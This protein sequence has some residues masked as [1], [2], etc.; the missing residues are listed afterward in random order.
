MTSGLGNQRSIQLSYAGNSLRKVSAG[1]PL[2]KMPLHHSLPAAAGSDE[3]N[4]TL[5]ERE[6]HW[7]GVVRSHFLKPTAR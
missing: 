6:D 5:C 2:R 3:E 1:L 4:Y 7:G